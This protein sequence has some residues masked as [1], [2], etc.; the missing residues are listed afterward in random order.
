MD[1][2]LL[3]NA[4][5]SQGGAVSHKLLEKGYQVLSP[6]RSERN[7]SILE[8]RNIQA[9]LTD[10][11]ARSLTPI[12]EKA[13]KVVLQ[14]PAAIAPS[15][16]VDIAKNATEAIK[17]AGN[18][19]TV[20][21]ISSTIP[22][23]YV[24]V[25]SVDARLKMVELSQEKMPNTPILSSTEYLE[26]FSTAYRQPIMENGVIPQTIPP[27]FPVNYLSWDDLAAYVIAA[28]ESSKLKGQI[29]PIGG[30]EGINGN[31]L[32]RRLGAVLGKELAY[33]PVSHQ[34]LEGILT[35]FMGAEVARDYAEFYYWQDI[36][37]APL[38]NPNTGELQN[39]LGIQLPSLEEWA[40][41]AFQE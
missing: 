20:L 5:G 10:F 19:K 27:D 22:N 34:Q 7:I 33:I 32:A 12:I 6:V 4:T 9:F 23:Q 41:Q 13:D 39:L 15:M 2:I 38:L 35:S 3:F 40:R 8:E 28:L 1:K 18:P 11:S 25:R 21:V 26:N 36:N 37:G 16:M 14:I 17:Q 31:D 29:Y 24:G 30:N